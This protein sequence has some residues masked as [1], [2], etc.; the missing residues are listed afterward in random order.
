MWVRRLTGLTL[1]ALAACGDGGDVA[2]RP[3]PPQDPD[4]GAAAVERDLAYC[5]TP[6]PEQTL[7]LYRPRDPRATPTPLVVYVHGGAWRAGDKRGGVW[8]E[9]IARAL[10]AEG[11]AV[12]SIDYRLAPTH[13]WP[14]QIA[15][16]RCAFA[17]LRSAAPDRGL[18]PDRIAAWGTSAGAH[19]A[20]LV[21]LDDAERALAA[22]VGLYGIYD[23]T[24]EGLSD[25]VRIGGADVF[26][27]LPGSGDPV[28]REA[29]PAL[30]A[31]SGDPPVMLVHGADDTVVP[32]GQSVGLEA[33]L[34]AA[35]VEVELVLVENAEHQL[36]EAG[37]PIAP[38]AEAITAAVV[39][40]FAERSRLAGR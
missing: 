28:L 37:A 25:L 2:T 8:F 4:L 12:A 32:A 10:L 9:R 26:G 22:F 7:D 6:D 30:L 29:S 3:E 35:G 1:L 21:A 36:L 18:D 38:S 27:V 39:T 14:R 31:S 19:L 24:V 5:A 20:A 34:R 40:F 16:V 17:F 13:P 23:L 33:R 11:F 15:D